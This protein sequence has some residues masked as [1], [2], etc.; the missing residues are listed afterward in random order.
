MGLLVMA[1]SVF[2]LVSLLSYDP[3]DPSFFS[4]G[5]AVGRSIHNWAGR[6]GAELAGDLFEVLGL[7]ALLFPPF[8]FVLGFKTLSV[9]G[10]P[11]PFHL[12]AFVLLLFS[13][14]LLS[15]LL[16]EQGILGLSIFDRP[17]GFV[18]NELN[19]RLSPLVGRFG[20]YLVTVTSLLLALVLFSARP[21]LTLVAL[22]AGT[23]LPFGFWREKGR[24]KRARPFQVKG[25]EK[26][27]VPGPQSLALPSKPE[28]WNA[29]RGTWIS[30][31]STVEHRMETQAME[32]ESPVPKG[33][34]GERTV[35]R[36]PSS[37][38][39]GFHLPPLSF[40]EQPPPQ[41]GGISEE[42]L[43]QNAEILEQKLRDFG[44]EGR[45]ASVQPGPVITRYEIEPAPG[46]KINRIVALADDLALAL[47]ALSVRVVAPIPGKAVVGIEIPNL[48]R[49]TVALREV[50]SAK[51]FQDSPSPLPLA[52]GVGIDGE[53][54]V[55]DLLQMPHLL[56]AG[57]T[58]SGKSICL[59][60]LIL[61]IL[62]KSTPREV[63]FLLIDPKRVELSIYDGLPHLADHVVFDA[64]EASKK[65][66]KVVAHMEER[67]KLFAEVGARNI[68]AYNRLRSP[69]GEGRPRP[70]PYLVVI[71]DEL[72]DLMLMAA[73]EVEGAIARL[74]QMA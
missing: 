41:R 73:A 28:T 24:T 31:P 63:R 55:A 26:S 61:S 74:A 66:H 12:T 67:Y 36:A 47:K 59:H 44:L 71:V 1:C 6:L 58:G 15:T 51:A 22:R 54:H 46:I 56:V 62:A 57:A 17:G 29:D 8:I 72:A 20:L 10:L 64:K 33:E 49:A 39:E 7:S 65:L 23:K 34:E 21:L 43:K 5:P 3:L 68:G 35:V 69:D 18:G 2:L 53:P 52:L 40:L 9:R 37:P 50:L 48:N 14:S 13:V 70:L 42:E 16:N 11:S 30:G 25:T 19:R 27:P 45:V 4:S 60:T 38:K 32:P